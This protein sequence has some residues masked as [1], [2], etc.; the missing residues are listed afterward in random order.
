MY[1]LRAK[2]FISTRLLILAVLS[3]SLQVST[4]AQQPAKPELQEVK[5]ITEEAYLYGFP[6]VVGYK[7]MYGFFID[8]NSGQFKAPINQINNEA[9][10][11][12]PKDTGISTPN[13]DTPYSMALLDL[14]AEPFVL[15]MPEI[16][17]S[18]YYDVQLVDLYTNNYGYMGSR[19]T[20]NGASCYLVAGPEWKGE[21]PK[22]IAKTFRSETEFSLVVY[23]T[24]LFNP[25]DIVNVE[26]IQAGYKVE[27][28]SSYLG[29]P[30]PPSA[31]AINWPKFEDNAF[32]TGFAEYLNFLLQFCPPV[33]TAA[34]EVPLRHKFA[35]IGIGAERKAAPKSVSPELKAAMGDGIKAAL[36]KIEETASSVGSNVNGWQIG[37]A[38]G[39]REFYHGD[40]ALRAAAAK[41]G[42]YGNSEAEAVYPYTRSDA[43]NIALDGSKHTYQMT[44]APEQLP[45]VKAFWSITMYD[46]RTQLL[47]ENPIERYLINSPMLPELKKNPDGSITIY[48]QHDSPGKE[49]ESNWLPAPNGPMF[50]A[51]RLYWPNTEPPS[52]FPLGKGTW[53]PPGLVAV[54]NLNALDVRRFGDKSLENFIRTDTRY[55]HDGLFQGPRGWG[56][57]NYL[58]YPRPVQNPNLWPDMQS[59]YFIGRLALPAGSTLTLNYTYPH[60]RYFQ[61]ALYKAQGTTFVSIGEALS[62]QD[63]EPDPG[64]K[65]PFRV[66]ADRLAEPRN[67]TLRIAA[68]NAPADPK[69]RPQNTLYAGKDGGELMFVNRA[70]LSD[71]G[72]DGAGWGPA[73][74]PSAGS[75]L[76]TYS[77]TLAHGTKLSAADVVK[78]FA[79]PFT[80]STKQPVTAEQW[81]MLV[82]SKENDPALDPATA[83]ARKDPRW[84]KY[85]NIRYSIVG[86]F[87]TPE[88]RAKIPYASAIDGGGDP[89]TMYMFVQLS[90]KF[91]PVYVMRGKM[92][93]FPNTYAGAGGRGLEVMPPAQTQYWSLVSCEAMPSGQIV[94]ALTDMQVPLDK[95]GYYTIVYSRKEDR[96]A[97]ATAQNGVAWIEWSP[98]GEGVDTPQNRTDFGMLMLRFIQN[99]PNWAQSPDKVTKPGLEESVMGPYYPRGE[100]MDKSTFEAIGPRK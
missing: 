18:R 56:Y 42:I 2:F 9:R 10:V 84:E 65:N 19:S 23:R 68:E 49:K 88:E 47:I 32:T 72:S 60:A 70:Y 54:G 50:I 12:T 78:Q 94:D 16:E 6:M 21:T 62:G 17:K 86:S 52:V 35:M 41:L 14:R 5:A 100:Y 98:R 81:E 53:A 28:L 29:K 38:A 48:V 93:T 33:G 37:A 71:Q 3:A 27:P 11:F 51:M 91:G 36:A 58:E 96:P 87:K 55:G 80:A 64:S 44:F 45:P 76:P 83:P 13:S 89:E 59:T 66:G 74:S 26:K 1:K 24:Q 61:F 31:P 43:N 7:V 90:R 67:F 4:F 69:Q 20:G 22:G 39:S 79:R 73:A 34:V 99:D 57:W 8:R 63:I 85:W 30:K 75:G 40:W 25:A 82:R 92:P 77:A 15:C 46:G 97:N 95:D